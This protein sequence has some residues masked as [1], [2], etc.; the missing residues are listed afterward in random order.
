MRYLS[1]LLF[2]FIF[3][4]AF[5]QRPSND[6]GFINYL[7]NSEQYDEA[8]FCLN[9]AE[10]N[11][12]LNIHSIDSINYLKGWTYYCQKK[13]DSSACS[14]SKVSIQ[15]PYYFKSKFFEAYNYCFLG[16]Y[17]K[18]ISIFSN[19]PEKDSLIANLKYFELSGLS[20]LQKDYKNYTLYFG[21]IVNPNYALANEKETLDE[22]Y[23]KTIHFRKKS[24]L[25]A[26][27]MSAIIPGS[28]KFYTGKVGEGFSSFIAVT[29]LGAITLENYRKAGPDN[30]KTILFGTLFA[31]FY[32]GNIYGS[33]ISVKVYRDEFYKSYEK[34]ILFNIHIPL[35]TIFN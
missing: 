6:L 5:A 14:F 10:S 19:I 9:K 32:L 4:S 22:V 21:K 7:I 33:M 15:S 24:M 30:F 12:F 17:D 25:A 35:R 27:T 28:G 8:I 2:I 20:L 23:N 1:I 13:L 3:Y 16:N 11:E 26:G 18:S 29:I 31:V 34:K